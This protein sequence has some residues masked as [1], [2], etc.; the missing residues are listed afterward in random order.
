MNYSISGVNQLVLLLYRYKATGSSRL[1]ISASGDGEA[2]AQCSAL[3]W[4]KVLEHGHK[5]ERICIQTKIQ[6]LTYTAALAPE[7]KNKLIL[8]LVSAFW[9]IPPFTLFI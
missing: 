4:L 5:L 1:I 7:G 9:E 8:M 3:L 6:N 2:L